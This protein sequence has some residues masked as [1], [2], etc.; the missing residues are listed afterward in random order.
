M[1]LHLLKASLLMTFAVILLG[2]YT[3]LADAGLGCPDWPGCYGQIS[4]PTNSDEIALANDLYPGLTVEA[5][6]AWLE[7]IHRYFAGTLGL[8]VFSIT[9][10]AIT[11]RQLPKALALSLSGIVLFQ[12][13]LGMW[14]VTMKLM[15]VVVMGHLLGGFT[16]FGLLA[17]SYWKAAEERPILHQSS[18]GQRVLATVGLC[19]LVGQIALGGWTSSNYAALMCTS[20]PICQGDW[21]N[22]LDF[23]HAF[24]LIQPERE[25]YEFGTLDYGARMTIH[26]SHRVGAMLVVA[27]TAVLAVGLFRSGDR[28]LQRLA[29]LMMSMIV[30]QIGLGVGNVVLSLPLPIAVAHNL[31]AALLLICLL[32]VNYLLWG[33]PVPD[34]HPLTSSTLNSSKEHIHE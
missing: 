25:S 27:L 6:K 34:T 29:T 24:E 1:L 4:V 15:P 3:R 11:R 8:L 19:V 7:M 14:T 26:V 10:V 13:V 31:G 16:L 20:L 9:F 28:N 32:R 12:A 22:H 23:K 18:T 5:N 17:L 2:A 33:T 21:Q 30:I